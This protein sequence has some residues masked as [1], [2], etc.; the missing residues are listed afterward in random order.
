MQRFQEGLCEYR[1]VIISGDD[2]LAEQT[3]THRDKR[4]QQAIFS[5]D[6]FEEL[7]GTEKFEALVRVSSVGTEAV[8]TIESEEFFLE[9]GE[10]PGKTAS[11]SGLLVR[12]L[13]EGAIALP[14]RAAFEAAIAGGHL[15]PRASEDK[16]GFITWKGERAGR[17]IRVLRP[18]LIRQV[19][20]DWIEREGAVGR[21]IQ[22]VRSDGSPVGGV[23]FE[24]IEKG[25]C[26]SALWERVRIASRALASDL[27]PLGLLVPRVF[28]NAG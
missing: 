7:E 3:V 10:A 28:Q 27:G 8:E 19:E 14:N 12:S 6:D 9:F 25:D 4:D 5:V 1:V 2:E 23:R 11:G 18:V 26:E 13:V 22:S 17:A 20:T 15:P 16:K 24:P 21:W